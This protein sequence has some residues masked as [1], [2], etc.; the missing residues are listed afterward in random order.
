[1]RTGITIFFLILM[2]S[3]Q[4]PVGQLFKIPLLIEHFMDHKQR[5]PLSLFGFIAEHYTSG[6]TGDADQREDEQLPF[7]NI[8]VN[9]VVHAIVPGAIRSTALVIVPA[10]KK[11]ML[12]DSYAPQ[13]HLAS[14]FHPPRV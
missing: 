14:I 2:V 11:M 3:S 13:Q 5:D 4:T 8:S 7:K 12:K 6:H 10:E 1:M 9:P